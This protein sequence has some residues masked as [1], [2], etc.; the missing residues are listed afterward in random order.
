MYMKKILLIKLS[1]QIILVFFISISSYHSF[2][3][4]MLPPFDSNKKASVSERIGVCDVTIHYNRPEVKGRE[5][6]IWGQVVH[7]GY[8]YMGPS[9]AAPWRAGAN[10]NTTIE[11]STDVMIEGKKLPAGKYGFFIAMSPENSTL[12][13]SKRSTAWGSFFYDA[14]EDALRVYVKAVPI[15]ELVERLKYE[16]SD[17]TDSSA[18]LSLQWEKLKIP[19]IISIDVKKEM[20]S[21][22]RRQVTLSS[23]YIYWQNLNYAADYCLKNNINLEEALIW[24]NE[25]IS[26]DF[27]DSNFTNLS[28]KAKLLEKLNRVNEA[29]AVMKKAIPI[30]TMMQ[31]NMYARSLLSQ[32]KTDKAFEM[33]QLNYKRHPNGINAL[34]GMVRGYSALNDNKEALKFAELA[35]KSAPDDNYKGMI[36]EMIGTLKQGKSLSY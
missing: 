15:N 29:E 4:I 27:G 13:F 32:K 36:T 23:F 31:L 16:F 25:S 20:I 7:Y 18:V 30:S 14:K 34:I 21:I 33:F 35:F 2:A 11:F 12:I 19:F 24:S 10:E 3:Q 8:K 28:V 6:R 1:R 26:G 9:I 17:Q 5:G 22:F